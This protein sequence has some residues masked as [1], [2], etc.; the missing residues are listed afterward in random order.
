MSQTNETQTHTRTGEQAHPAPPTD[1][2][3]EVKHAYQS[4]EQL[5]DRPASVLAGVQPALSSFEGVGVGADSN[6]NAITVVRA[7]TVSARSHTHA[8]AHTAFVRLRLLATVPPIAP[9]RALVSRTGRYAAFRN[10]T[11]LAASRAAYSKSSLRR[12][13]Q[14]TRR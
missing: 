14:P 4:G 3:S 12:P 13:T 10:T 11:T 2:L 7:R 6:M 8:R 1:E 5:D 9:A